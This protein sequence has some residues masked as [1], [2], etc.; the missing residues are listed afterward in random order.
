MAGGMGLYYNLGTFENTALPS[1]QLPYPWK[2][3]LLCTSKMTIA[4][5]KP[6][7]NSSQKSG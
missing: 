5:D 4:S 6:T 2:K 1:S 3:I 7:S